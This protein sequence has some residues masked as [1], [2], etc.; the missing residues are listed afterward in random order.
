MAINLQNSK[1]IIIFEFRVQWTPTAYNYYIADVLI[2]G[3]KELIF[4]NMDTRFFELEALCD[5]NYIIKGVNVHLRPRGN[6]KQQIDD[7]GVTTC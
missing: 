1:R 7:E 5:A 3:R 2:F 4:N 6:Q